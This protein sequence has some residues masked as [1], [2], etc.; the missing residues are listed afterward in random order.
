MKKVINK[1]IFIFLLLPMLTGCEKDKE[2][3]VVEPVE[4]YTQLYGLGTIFSWDS[5][6]PTELKLTEPNTFTIDK[7]IKYSEENKQ[8]KFILEKGDWDK[9]RYL[10]PTSTDDGTAVKVITP[11]EYDMLMCSE[12][13]GDLRDHFWGI[14]EGSD[15]TYR[16]TVNVK[17]LKLTLEKISDETEE[18]EPEIKT[19][20]GL[21][22]AFGWDSGSATGLVPDPL[23]ANVYKAEVNLVYSE[24]NKQFKFILEKGDWDKVNYLVPESVDYNGNVKIVTPGEYPMFKCSEMEGNLRDHFWGIPEGADGKYILTVNTETMILKVE[25]VVKTIYGLGTAF[26]WDSGNPTGLIPSPDEEDIYTAEVDLNYS[27]ENKQ[28][29]FCLEKGDWD[30]VNY[31]V[32]ESVDYNENVKIVTP[33]EYP[34]F[35]CS[36]MTGDLRDHF[37]GIPE[38]SDGK[39]KLTVNTKT[40]KL[41]VEKIN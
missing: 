12:M 6:A 36:E 24:E 29:K 11:G 30:K 27:D 21:G 13:T 19:I 22:S 4:N 25:K 33:G 15:G 14:P 37:W 3:V 31:L 18:P 7:V 8:F 20:Y 16:I 28:F 1:L 17:K 38:G 2:I 35:K 32:P 5:N 26:G 34:M 40:L 9:V 23:Y 10:V 39:Y 41:K